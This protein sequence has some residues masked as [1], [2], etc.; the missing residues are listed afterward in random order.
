MPKYLLK[1]KSFEYGVIE[2]PPNI[3]V[4]KVVEDFREGKQKYVITYL[5]E[6][7]NQKKP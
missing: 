3:I 5:Q 4:V 6:L 7:P 1:T 2:L